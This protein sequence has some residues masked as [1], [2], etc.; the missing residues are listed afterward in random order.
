MKVP[1][2]RVSKDQN[3][4]TRNGVKLRFVES[5]PRSVLGMTSLCGR[6]YY[7][8]PPYP[9]CTS[10]PCAPWGRLD[11]KNGYFKKVMPK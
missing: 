9:P 10:V 7:G 11:G 8:K 1:R 5:R 6:C 3:T 2:T 4:V